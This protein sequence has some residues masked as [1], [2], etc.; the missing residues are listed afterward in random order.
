M[1]ENV[2]TSNESLHI[3]THKTAP[4]ANIPY[5]LQQWFPTFLACDPFKW[6]ADTWGLL[7]QIV[8]VSGYDQAN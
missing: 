4:T 7:S 8:N 3:Y 5:W 6:S 1:K 2:F